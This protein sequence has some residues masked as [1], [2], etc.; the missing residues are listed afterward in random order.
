GMKFPWTRSREIDEE[1]RAH[2]R[3]AIRD[4]IEHGESPEEAKRNVQREFG[5]ELMVWETARDMW[6]WVK[7]ERW[8]RDLIY[9]FRQVRRSPGLAAIA[10]LTL[11]LGLGATTSMFSI[12]NSVLLD[13][14]KY[15]DPGRLYSV[16]NLPP[17]SAPDRLWS[18]NARHFYEWRAHCES[19]ENIA[20]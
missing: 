8:A 19:C 2:F 4:R 6:G 13:P 14:L 12:V 18:I 10:V 3:M 9:S 15:R 7:L 11:G 20:L 1:L 5:N 17:P 16:V